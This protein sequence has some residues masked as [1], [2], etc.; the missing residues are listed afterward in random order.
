M[1]KARITIE[2]M[3]HV[4]LIVGMI[5]GI[6]I[7]THYTIEGEIEREITGFDML[8]DSESGKTLEDEMAEVDSTETSW[9]YI[10]IYTFDF[11]EDDFN[12][13]FI[14][15]P[16]QKERVLNELEINKEYRDSLEKVAYNQDSYGYKDLYVT[17]YLEEGDVNI[18]TLQ[19][20]FPDID[21]SNGADMQLQV[22]YIHGS[23]KTAKYY[24]ISF[25]IKDNEETIIE[26]VQAYT[27]YT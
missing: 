27:F 26:V 24:Q 18:Q 9:N 22:F 17:Y 7:F 11:K 5:L 25:Y 6:Y 21:F 13:L 16:E 15:S 1:S 19:D 10:D 2:I 14:A 3:V 4:V 8:Y 12:R 23:S 20:I